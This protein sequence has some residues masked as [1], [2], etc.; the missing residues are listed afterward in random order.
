MIVDIHN[1][2]FFGQSTGMFIQSS[3]K[4]EAFIYLTFIKKKENGSWEKLSTGEG[5]TV[6]CSLEEIVMILE[7]LK[8]NQK[9]WSTVHSF[10]QEKTSISVSWEGESKIWFN[11]GE[12]PKMLTFGQIEILKLL[13]HHIL[14]EKIE[15]STVPDSSKSIKHIISKKDSNLRAS[16]PRMEG[17]GLTIHEEMNLGDKVSKLEGEI[18]GETEKA[19]RLK[20]IYGDDVWFP[21]STIKSQ[22]NVELV[23]K[24]TFLIDTWILEKNSLIPQKASQQE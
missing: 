9:S 11:V 17:D 15:H 6:K 24:Q 1:Q 5:K 13:L 7:V 19:L 4:A 3:S 14:K 23:G 21:K 10:K 18:V 22:F 16:E 20:T 2:S 12:Y 8:K